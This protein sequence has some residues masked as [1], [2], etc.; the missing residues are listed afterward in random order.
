MPGPADLL[1]AI[2]AASRAIPRSGGPVR[3]ALPVAIATALTIAAVPVAA[4]ADIGRGLPQTSTSA[5]VSGYD[6]ESQVSVAGG[7]D[8]DTGSS[9]DSSRSACTWIAGV[10][11]GESAPRPS[12]TDRN[13]MAFE[14]AVPGQAAHE[15]DRAGTKVRLYGRDCGRGLAWYWVPVV[16]A[17]QLAA[18]AAD[19]VKQRV[20]TPAAVF[21]P[22]LAGGHSALVQLPLWFAVPGEQWRPVTATADVPGLI[23][24]AVARPVALT[25]Q[26]GDGSAAVTCP[27]PGSRWRAGMQEPLM[28]PA[29]SF[30][31]RNASSAA[32]DG[33]AWTGRVSI[34]WH[35]TW[36]ATNS[37]GGDL[38][39]ITTGAAHRIPVREVQAIE[40]GNR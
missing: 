17:E 23:A 2:T 12:G 29:C 39:D 18:T 32:P 28:P 9:G 33:Q 20:P 11:S 38:G 1:M 40:G 25:F 13:P 15:E 34:R 5:A 22:N 30:T 4:R 21:S 7:T 19:V 31:Y 24:T 26:T 37:R 6:I 35:I 10:F 14:V 36:T 8:A 16:T 3:R 27:G